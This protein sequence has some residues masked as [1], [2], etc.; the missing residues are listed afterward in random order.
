MSELFLSLFLGLGLSGE[1][2][3]ELPM[4]KDCDCKKERCYSPA[5]LEKVFEE[6]PEENVCYEINLLG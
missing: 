1:I 4:S 6:V 2:N 5:K 3:T